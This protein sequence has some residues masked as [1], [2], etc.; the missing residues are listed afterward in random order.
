VRATLNGGGIMSL[1]FGR[2]R[3]ITA[4]QAGVQQLPRL[5]L[6][7]QPLQGDLAATLNNATRGFDIGQANPIWVGAV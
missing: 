5:P 2:N 7:L 1:L 3:A 4:A 6:P